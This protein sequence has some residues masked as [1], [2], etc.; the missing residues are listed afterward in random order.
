MMKINSKKQLKIWKKNADKGIVFF[1]PYDN[2]TPRTLREAESGNY[3][4]NIK[5]MLS[6]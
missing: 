1:R 4:A 5:K 6:V 2:P 3:L